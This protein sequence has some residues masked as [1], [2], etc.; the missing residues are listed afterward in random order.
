KRDRRL[1]ATADR[2][3]LLRRQLDLAADLG[4]GWLAPELGAQLAL[5]PDDLVQL[6]DDVHR[7]PDRARLVRER[8]GD[9]LPDPPGRVR[10]ELE[11]LAVVELLGR[12]NEPDRPLLDQIEEG[13]TLVAVSL[14]DRDD[15]T[16]VR[17]D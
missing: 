2:L 12:A 13:Q 9:G 5:G 6:L 14:G 15:Q 3:D 4:G 17:L 10:R 16:Q 8:A 7:H 11:S 1:R